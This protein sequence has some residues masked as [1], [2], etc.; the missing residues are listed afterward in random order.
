M[1]ND[2]LNIILNK[3]FK[4]NKKIYFISGNEIT[5]MEKIRVKIIE[6][7]QK[8]ENVFLENIDL[9]GDFN[10]T[11]G[12]FGEKK[13]YLVK[14]C[15]GL[16]EIILNKIK[17]SN[18]VFIF[19]QENSQKL[20]KLKA[21]LVKDNEVS[22]V[23]CYQLDKSLKSRVLNEFF[24]LPKIAIEKDLYWLL[25]EK[26]D[27]R[28]G[29][30]EDSLNKILELNQEDITLKNI[31]KILSIS[32]TG[33]EK[34]FFSILNKNK[35]IIKIFR[36]KIIN[37]TDVN[38]LYYYCKFFCQLIIDSKNEDEYNNKIPAYLFKE[39]AFLINLYRRYN[40]EKKKLLLNL[41]S[42]TEKTLRK[43]SGLS[44]ISGLRFFLNIKKITVS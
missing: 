16:D 20:K 37:I 13:I 41:L 38:D 9:V 29:F 15:K 8:T 3:D 40:T 35:D 2:P 28:Y 11:D 44:L 17:S 6:N 4:F 23:D 34:I 1:K 22:L 19:V 39:K 24:K 12:L 30:L 5:L 18:S 32:D 27:D 42:S 26:L 21:M 31:T 36:E 33:K 14:N 7:Y 25:V 10:D 43:E